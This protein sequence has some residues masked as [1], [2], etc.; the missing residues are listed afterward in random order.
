MKHG[1][2]ITSVD[3]FKA[4]IPFHEPFR[5]AIAEIPGARN[6][7]VRV[8]TSEGLYGFGEAAP[9]SSITGET[10][11]TCLAGAAD[12][13]RLLLGRDPLDIDGRMGEIDAFLVHSSALRCAF[14]TALHDLAGK[15]AG[16]P[17]YALLGGGRRSFWTDITVGLGDPEAMAHKAAGYRDQGFH[18]IKVKLGTTRTRDVQRIA[19]IR[20]AVG[21]DVTIRIDANQGWDRSTAVQTLEA[22]EPMGIEFCEQPVAH[23]DHEGMRLVRMETSIPI[24]ADES[25]FDHHDALKLASAGCCDLFNIKLAKSGGIRTALRIH[26]I[27]GAASIPCMVGCMAETRLGMTAAA[28]LVSSR[29]SIRHADLDIHFMLRQDPVIGGITYAVGEIALPEAPG[30]GCDVDPSFLELCESSTVK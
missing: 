3:I 25:L 14:D 22:L 17:L 8:N 13:A 24:V 10:Q 30:L 29:P 23:W 4:D 19:A 26:S 6:V 27:A 7:L 15:V 2:E 5:I 1:L 12:L 18:V 28:H 11:A 20:E 21:S 9:I 16:L